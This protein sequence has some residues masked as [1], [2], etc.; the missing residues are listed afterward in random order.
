MAKELM[1][2]PF[3]GRA[4]EECA[5]YRGRHYFLCFVEKYRGHINNTPKV[6][7]GTGFN[8]GLEVEMPVITKAPDAFD[9]FLKPMNDI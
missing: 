3:S 4:C 7:T 8:K 1:R 5:E 2:C 9:P 6:K